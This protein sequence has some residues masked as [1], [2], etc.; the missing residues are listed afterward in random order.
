MVWP[1]VRWQD[2]PWSHGVIFLPKQTVDC[3]KTPL[4]FPA[5]TDWYPSSHLVESVVFKFCSSLPLVAAASH[6]TRQVKHRSS[7]Q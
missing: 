4:W 6:L 5:L 1:G 7:T 2:A 3:T